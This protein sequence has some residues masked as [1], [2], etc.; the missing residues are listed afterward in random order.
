MVHLGMARRWLVQSH[1][2]V[3]CVLF[4]IDYYSSNHIGQG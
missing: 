4:D 2:G 3:A 1:N